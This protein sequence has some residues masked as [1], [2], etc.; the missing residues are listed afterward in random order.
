MRKR[1]LGDRYDGYKI[2][3]VDPLFQ[4]IPIIMRTRLD[5]QVLFDETIDITALEKFIKTM[6]A[7]EM[8]NLR[9]IHVIMAAAVRTISQR[10]RINRF[11]SGKKIYAR[12]Y[13]RF[14]IAVKRKMSIDGEETTVMPEFQPTDTLADVVKTLDR[15][16]AENLAGSADSENDTDIIAKVVGAC[17][18]FL[19]SM[20]V[21]LV[22]GLDN[23]GLLPRFINQASP[24]HS[25]VFITDVGSL[26]IGP[27][28]HHLYEFG[29]CSMFLAVGKK[30]TQTVLSEDGAP[31]AKK[32][33]PIRLVVDERICD[34][35]YHA[36]AIK[37]FKKYMKNP[38]LLLTPPENVV[39]DL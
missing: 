25:S 5:S 37:L 7:G 26:G 10:P 35:F 13:I 23:H 8:P 34:G 15:V 2:R 36:S 18:T 32:L 22:R 20:V 16:F 38:Q 28:Y 9:L 17:P 21:A 39:E 30:E 19:K 6:R 1:R 24:F 3:K 14:S 31:M 27:V 33:L 12:S 11:V 29:T 4:L